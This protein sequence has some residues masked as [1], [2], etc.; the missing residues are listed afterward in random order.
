MSDDP[1]PKIKKGGKKKKGVKIPHFQAKK[2]NKPMQERNWEGTRGGDLSYGRGEMSGKLRQGGTTN[3]RPVPSCIKVTPRGRGGAQE[4]RRRPETPTNA[5][6]DSQ[7]DS[8]APE[9]RKKGSQSRKAGG[10][11]KLSGAPGGKSM[12][13]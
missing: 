5:A 11:G 3:R 2:G 8:T 9:G 4:L 10:R 12:G 13:R 1:R 6:K 7:R